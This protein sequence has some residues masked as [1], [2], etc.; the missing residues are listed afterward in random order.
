MSLISR[1]KRDNVTLFVSTRMNLQRHY[2][3][4]ERFAM[5][6]FL[7]RYQFRFQYNGNIL[8]YDLQLDLNGNVYDFTRDT[9]GVLKL[10]GGFF[11]KYFYKYLLKHQAFT[12]VVLSNSSKVGQFCPNLSKVEASLKNPFTL[13]Y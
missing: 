12:K 5:R 13:I 7:S 8:W 1:Q 9:N 6:A 10:R 3:G 2:E 4:M 11:Y